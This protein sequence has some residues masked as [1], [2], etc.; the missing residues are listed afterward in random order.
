MVLW[1]ESLTSGKA[2]VFFI[3]KDKKDL[4]NFLKKLD[5]NTPIKIL[6]AGSNILVRDGGIRGV[7][8]SLVK[9]FSNI[10]YYKNQKILVGAGVNC[11]KLSRESASRSMEGLEF[12]SGIP[13]SIGGAV[14]MN[15]GAYENE[16][17][18]II[19]SVETYNLESREIEILSKEEIDRIV[20]IIYFPFF[21]LLNHRRK[22]E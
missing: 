15:A 13:G 8:I 18:D 5:N 19:K 9:S 7:T 10:L 2:E 12:F 1:C 20:P 11:I 4:I 16:F 22:L 21:V 17:A 3:P 6:G 14:K